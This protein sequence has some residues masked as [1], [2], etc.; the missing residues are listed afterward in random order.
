MSTPITIGN[1]VIQFPTSGE[2]SDWA[3]AIV[4]FAEAVSTALQGIASQFDISPRAQTLTSDANTNLNISDVIF[5]NGS[6]RGFT[7]NYAVYRTNS[8]TALAETGVVTGVYDTLAGSWTLQHDFQ[9]P[10]QSD[11]TIYHGFSMSG[12]Q[13]QFSCSAL[14]GT[15]DNTNSKISYAAKTILVSDS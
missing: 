6:V 4:D 7:F 9:G 14:G 3:P 5:P 15:Y 10:R 2:S 13:M 1:Q 11:G 8:V 12:D